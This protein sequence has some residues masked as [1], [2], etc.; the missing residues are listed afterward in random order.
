MVLT[1]TLTV[2][3]QMSFVIVLFFGNASSDNQD[4]TTNKGNPGRRS[5]YYP[6]GLITEKER[7][8]I[9][10]RSLTHRSLTHRSLTHRSL[11]TA[12]CSLAQDRII[13]IANRP[14]FVE[15]PIQLLHVEILCAES[16]VRQRKIFVPVTGSQP[17]VW[18][19][20]SVLDVQI[21]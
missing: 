15:V 16:L 20:R 1:L 11:L 10:H 2:V 4:C 13:S 3:P 17:M 18:K 7:A 6:L 8:S 12:H 19:P 21:P 9:T 5:K 14:Y